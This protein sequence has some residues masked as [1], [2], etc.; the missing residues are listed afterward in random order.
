[1]IFRKFVTELWPLINVRILFPLKLLITYGL[2]STNIYVCID[3]DKLKVVR[4]GMHGLQ[5]SYSHCLMLIGIVIQTWA[6]YSMKSAE[7]GD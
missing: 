5:H 1:M 7:F 2:N 6:F 4:I 3:I